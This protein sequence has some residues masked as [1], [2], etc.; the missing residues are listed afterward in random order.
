MVRE[1]VDAFLRSLESSHENGRPAARFNTIAAYRIDLEQLVHYL[2]AHGFTTFAVEPIDLVEYKRDLEMRYDSAASRA[3]KI[4]AV[5]ALYKYL[6]HTKV[7]ERNPAQRLTSPTPIKKPPRVISGEQLRQLVE[8]AR[9][10]PTH[11]TLEAA[12]LQR[13]HAMLALLSSTGIQAS[14]LVALNLADVAPDHV[15]TVRTTSH[16]RYVSPD[17]TTAAI[18]DG[19]V[20]DARRVLQG[21][22]PADD[23]LFLNHRGHRLTR[24]GFWLII[25]QAAERVGITGISPRLLRHSAAAVKLNDGV[26]IRDV[27]AL[28]GHANVATTLVYANAVAAAPNDDEQ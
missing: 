13:D 23:A 10:G 24:Q 7:I 9:A 2:T 17:L 19:Y 11:N 4:A 3:R 25:K 26:E 8:G 1:A 6:L 22:H 16:N 28:L 5:R 12:M 21:E 18:I 20:R 14:E 15:V 27:Q